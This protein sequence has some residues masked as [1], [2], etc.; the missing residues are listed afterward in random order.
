MNET[1]PLLK[2]TGPEFLESTGQSLALHKQH[3]FE[4]PVCEIFVFS[5]LSGRLPLK[6]GGA[7]WQLTG[8]PHRPLLIYRY[9]SKKL[10]Y[11]EKVQCF[12]SVVL[13]SETV[14]LYRFITH[15]VKYVK[16]LFLVILIIVAYR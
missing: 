10:E 11:R 3:S 4:G 1:L 12:F 8:S 6:N 9:I 7:S 2:S 13:E 5:S 15:T 14:T 16:L